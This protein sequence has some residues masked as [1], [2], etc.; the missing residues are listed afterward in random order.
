MGG[1][2]HGAKNVGHGNLGQFWN[3]FA[4]EGTLGVVVL[5]LLHWVVD[6]HCINACY[7]RLHLELGIVNARLKIQELLGQMVD[8]PLATAATNDG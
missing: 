4:N 6:A 1:I 2:V 8:P 7:T 5:R 3:P